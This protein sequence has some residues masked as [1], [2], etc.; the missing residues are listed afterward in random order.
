MYSSIA[1]LNTVPSDYEL[2]MQ[3]QQDGYN[4]QAD[5]DLFTN[6]Q[7]FDFD[8]A[9]MPNSSPT[10]FNDADLMLSNSTS[11]LPPQ[12]LGFYDREF[13]VYGGFHC[14]FTIKTDQGCHH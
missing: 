2:A 14:H 3:Q 13:A 4:M 9:E 6:A 1:N 10:G 7:F 12:P 8:M 11:A 5:L